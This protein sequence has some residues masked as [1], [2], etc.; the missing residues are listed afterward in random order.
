MTKQELF[1][2][3][4]WTQSILLLAVMVV[5]ISFTV[6]V[7]DTNLFRQSSVA[8]KGDSVARASQDQDI[9]AARNIELYQNQVI[10]IIG[11]YFGQRLAFAE[12]NYD[13][14]F[15]ASDTRNR[16]IDL[17]VPYAYRPL[18]LSL[19]AALDLEKNAIVSSDEPAATTAAAAWE[20]IF[21]E[22]YWLN[23]E[24]KD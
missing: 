16:L 4:H 7:E 1:I 5:S 18:H 23:K 20:R 19:L 9:A 17:S 3:Y 21:S 22:Y 24:I 15:L 14:L 8:V 13:W 2:K 11:G 10:K 12:G 6:V